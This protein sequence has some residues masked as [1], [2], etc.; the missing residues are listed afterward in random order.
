MKSKSIFREY[1][2]LVNTIRRAGK[3][4][5]SEINDKWLDTEMSEG[6]EI[7]RTTF[8]R[9]KSAIEEMFG[10]IIDCDKRNGYGYYIANPEVLREDSVQ[11]WLL[12]T[13]SVSDIVSESISLQDRIVMES[14][15]VE[16][17]LLKM[18]I[19]SMKRSVKLSIDHCRYGSDEVKTFLVAPYGIKL[20]KHRWYL[21]G[22][23]V[24]PAV[25]DKPERCWI[26][27]LSLDR[28]R[29]MS[30]TDTPFVV[31]KDFDMEAFF[32]D[33]Y[34]V[35]VDEQL[36][37]ERVVVRAFDYQRYYLQD[38]PLHH[39]QRLVAQGEDYADFEYHIRIT[40]DFAYA[41]LGMGPSAMVLEP[42]HLA[43]DVKAAHQSAAHRYE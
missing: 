38:L 29:S 11:N 17:N 1:V 23:V 35:Y 32:R 19:E 41:L 21:V 25:D 42:Q 2:W 15:P 27:L 9:H 5:L 26:M 18:A 3:I 20:F 6:V 31:D 30:L 10:I 40:D 28:I 8:N 39:S 36:P 7:A 22:R 37:V 43:D 13:L 34:G 24:R 4:S 14:A 33:S 12:G 16:G